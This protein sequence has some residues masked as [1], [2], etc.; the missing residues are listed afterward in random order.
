MKGFTLIELSIVLV[1]IG[2]IVGGILV[3]AD[4]IKAAEIRATVSQVE[5]FN[6]SV[7]TFRTK[8]GVMPGDIIS[9]QAAAFGLFSE[10]ALAGTPGHQD[11]NGMIEGGSAGATVSIGETL[12]FWR[13]LSDANLLEASLGTSGNSAIVAATGLLT[14][15]VTTIS[16][17]LPAAKTTPIVYYITYSQNGLNFYQ[18]LSVSQITAATGALTLGGTG[19]SPVQ[20]YNI[21]VKIDDGLP[22][23]GTIVGRGI[24]AVN[25]VPSVN[26]VST[27]NMCTIGTGVTSDTYNR[28]PAS[29]GTDASCSLRFRFN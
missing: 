27:A 1:I 20:A 29:G 14:G 18:L 5:K 2:L 16:Q 9:T 12:A 24:A 23:A 28:V 15:N 25:A 21:D 26:A 7:N 17:S 13:H 8:F 19:V 10:T 3:G 4:M 22:N 11:G 6:A